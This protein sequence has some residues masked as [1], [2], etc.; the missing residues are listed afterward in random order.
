MKRILLV[1]LAVMMVVSLWGC[2]GNE[3]VRGQVSGNTK[4]AGEETVQQT[5]PAV[6]MGKTES[7]VYKNDFLGISCA[8]SSDWVFYTDEQIRELNNFAADAAGEEFEA[9]HRSGSEAP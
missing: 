3:D 7:N 9:Q 5:E 8:L 1:L 2:T 6:S 4:P